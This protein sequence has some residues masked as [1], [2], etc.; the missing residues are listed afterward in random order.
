[1]NETVEKLKKSLEKRMEEVNFHRIDC[2]NNCKFIDVSYDI[3]EFFSDYLKCDKHRAYVRPDRNCDLY[4][5]RIVYEIRPFNWSNSN[6]KDPKCP[7]CFDLLFWDELND[8]WICENQFCIINENEGEDPTLEEYEKW[9][10]EYFAQNQS[11]TTKEEK[12]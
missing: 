5:S 3:E 2:C 6:Q 12:E 7:Y 10:R 9:A 8:T 4:E 11:S 1:M